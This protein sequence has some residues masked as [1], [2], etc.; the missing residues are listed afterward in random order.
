VPGTYAVAQPGTYWVPASYVPAG[1]SFTF[2]AGHW[3]R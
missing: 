3:A 2:V 1:A